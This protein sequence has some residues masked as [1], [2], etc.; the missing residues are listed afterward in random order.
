MAIKEILIAGTIA[1]IVT[2]AISY[3][4][5]DMMPSKKVNEQVTIEEPTSSTS[6]VI[7]ELEPPTRKN[8]ILRSNEYAPRVVVIKNMEINEAQRADMLKELEA[9]FKD[10]KLYFTGRIEKIS[11]TY[12]G[13]EVNLNDESGYKAECQFEGDNRDTVYALRTDQTVTVFGDLRFFLSE[14][15]N[16]YL[17]K[18]DVD[19]RK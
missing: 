6:D 5:V 15:E 8:D 4:V 19:K 1:V 14:G 11:T 12:N 7:A 2:A 10:K 9:E 18:C 16:V 17:D 13:Y 3:T